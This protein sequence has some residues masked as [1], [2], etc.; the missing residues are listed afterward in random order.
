MHHQHFTTTIIVDQSPLEV[1]NAVNNVRGWWSE[2]IQGNSSQ[3]N[4]EFTFEVKDVHYSKQKL[5]EVIPGKK[6]VWLVTDSHLSFLEDKDEW[7]GTKAIF[8]ISEAGNKTKLVFT[9]EGLLPEVE[10]YKMCSPAWTEYVQH[11]LFNLITT[12]KGDPNL[13]GRRIKAI[14]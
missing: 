7:T 13:E 11:S 9:H 5:T 8:E 12:G 14:K 10:C 4:D 3:L 6:V 2:G 1:F